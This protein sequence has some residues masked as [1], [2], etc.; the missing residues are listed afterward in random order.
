MYSQETLG[1][2]MRTPD[3]GYKEQGKAQPIAEAQ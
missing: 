2:Q 1:L 3:G